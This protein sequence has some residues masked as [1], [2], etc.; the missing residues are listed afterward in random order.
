[1]EMLPN[2]IRQHR[3][4]KSMR[5]YSTEEVDQFLEHLATSLESLLATRQRSEEQVR[6][7]EKEMSKYRDQ[8]GALKKAVFTVEQA[9]T[10]AREA[11]VKEV[12][13]LKKTAELRAR[14][15]VSDAELERQRLEQDLKF[16][17]D[18]RQHYIEQL[19]S[20]CRAQLQTL[21]NLE[22]PDRAQEAARRAIMPKRTRPVATQ[23][24]P[25]PA[26][27]PAPTPEHV[28]PWTPERVARPEKEAA[29]STRSKDEESAVAYPPPL[30]PDASGDST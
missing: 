28:R 4:R 20:F 6:S 25:A 13:S 30:V 24:E 15:I 5:G 12:D 29:E 21:E 26:P 1:M 16:L 8:E 27:A 3:F 23:P 9:M 19:K 11:S 18:S 17:K 10:Q 2:D 14:Q 22:R 7:L